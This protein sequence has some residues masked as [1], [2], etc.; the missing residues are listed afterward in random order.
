MGSGSTIAGVAWYGD[1]GLVPDA[2]PF[3]N[4]GGEAFVTPTTYWKVGDTH[5]P[6]CKICVYPYEINLPN[7]SCGF[8]AELQPEPVPLLRRNHRSRHRRRAVRPR[9]LP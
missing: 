7:G 4:N 8:D 9:S 3:Y 1:G 5:T 2:G 6:V